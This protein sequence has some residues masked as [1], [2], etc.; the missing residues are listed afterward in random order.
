MQLG[1]LGAHLFG[2]QQLAALE[3]GEEIEI[4]VDCEIVLGHDPLVVLPELFG[5]QSGS[6]DLVRRKG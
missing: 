5:V 2:V 6:D 1:S 4:R 3:T